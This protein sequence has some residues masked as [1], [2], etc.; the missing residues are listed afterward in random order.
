MVAYFSAVRPLFRRLPRLF[1]LA[2]LALP[3]A[4]A[5]AADA[6]GPA[7]LDL[8]AYKGH[9]VYLDFWASWCGP[10]KLSFPYM[11]NLPYAFPQKGLVVLTVNV[12]HSKKRADAF[13]NEVGSQLPVIYDPK[14]KLATR[15]HVEA[16]PSAV[17]IDR[18]GKVRFVHKGFY[19]DKEGDYT[20]DVATLI[21]EK[22]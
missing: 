13:L 14:G 9:V 16:M 5:A 18:D 7:A 15:F 17:L 4:G 19:E 2:F 21:N 6:P 3:L 8:S 10:C 11:E 12:D 1:C 20:A 22:Q